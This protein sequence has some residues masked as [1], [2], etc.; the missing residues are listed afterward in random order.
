MAYPMCS[1]AILNQLGDHGHHLVVVSK[2]FGKQDREKFFL[3]KHPFASGADL[4]LDP[5]NF[6]LYLKDDFISDFA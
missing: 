3:I 6:T 2:Q 4:G 5:S 1:S